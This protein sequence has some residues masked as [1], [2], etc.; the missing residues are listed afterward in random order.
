MSQLHPGGRGCGQSPQVPAC[1]SLTLL[2]LQNLKI[3]EEMP[4]AHLL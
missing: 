1:Q 3:L 2:P 4:R